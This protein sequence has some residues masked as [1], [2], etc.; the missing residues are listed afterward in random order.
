[1]RLTLQDTE[2]SSFIQFFV[3][4]LCNEPVSLGD[5]FQGASVR[6]LFLV[7]KVHLS[8][9]TFESVFNGDGGAGDKN[10]ED[11]EC[12]TTVAVPIFTPNK[13]VR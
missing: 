8:V 9:L 3:D 12:D 2:L 11:G 7:Q 10:R 1:M 13:E 5:T 6:L 4:H